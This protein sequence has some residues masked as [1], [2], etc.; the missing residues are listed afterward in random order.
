LLEGRRRGV[1]GGDASNYNIGLTD[2]LGQLFVL[3]E[4]FPKPDRQ[5]L[6]RGE[7]RVA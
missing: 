3:H 6:R 7:N 1:L 2:L 5:P 4:R